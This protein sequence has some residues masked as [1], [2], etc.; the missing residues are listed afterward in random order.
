MDI[1]TKMNT[2]TKKSYWKEIVSAFPILSRNDEVSTF[3]LRLVHR[4][5]G[6]LAIL[7]KIS[8]E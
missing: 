6:K 4:T 7:L 2:S 8:H 5:G 3:I 1:N